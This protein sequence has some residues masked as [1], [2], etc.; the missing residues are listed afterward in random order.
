MK[1]NNNILKILVVAILFL[2]VV[3]SASQAVNV[4]DG[5]IISENHRFMIRCMTINN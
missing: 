3:A 4:F 2:L 5:K 1:Q